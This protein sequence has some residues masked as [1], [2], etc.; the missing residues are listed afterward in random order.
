VAPYKRTD[1][2]FVNPYNFVSIDEPVRR[3]KV[4]YGGLTG[5]LNCTLETLTPLFVPNTTNNKTFS[6]GPSNSY[7]FYSYEDLSRS[8]ANN[9][10][11]FPRPIIPGSAIRGAIRAAYEAVTNSCLSTSDDENTLYRRTVVP[12]RECGIIVKENS[13]RVLYK[14]EK[15]NLPVALRGGH[16]MGAELRGGYY[17]R[18]EDFR[19]KKNDAIMI[20]KLDDRGERILTGK[21]YNESDDEWKRIYEVWRLYQ[22]KNSE[23][24]GV[25]QTSGH[26]AYKG[27]L[28]VKNMP[29]YYSV[30]DGVY[31]VSPACMTK[32]VFS[33]TVKSML[34]SQGGHQPCGDGKSLC[35]ACRLFGMVG[36]ENSRS[37]RLAFRDAKPV[38]DAEDYRDWYEQPRILPILSGPKISATEFYM[39][40]VAGAALFN[41]DYKTTYIY[42][43]RLQKKVPITEQ[44][45]NPKLRGRKFYWHSREVV[46]DMTMDF[47]RQRTEIRPVTRGKRFTFE[48]AFEQLSCGE[49]A[50]L[51]YTL[52]FGENAQTNAHKLGHGKPVG[53]GSVR[54]I[55]DD[56][57]FFEV[58]GGNFK[59]VEKT[60]N[61][62]DY[63]RT[64]PSKSVS[65]CEYLKLTAFE[66]APT[67][68][69]YPVAVKGRNGTPGTYAWF[70]INKEIVGG[71]QRPE[72]ND[73]LPLPLD[74]EVYVRGYEEGLGDKTGNRKSSSDGS[75]AAKA[76]T[77][78]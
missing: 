51:I 6:E 75:V 77:T 21:S 52:T 46:R 69:R 57:R 15:A 45:R 8:R 25:N 4:A 41:Y 16:K 67:P 61:L 36:D 64:P 7:D 68:V 70:G 17:L 73:V 11:R 9:G 43:R 20:F 27:W 78:P 22:Q 50:K 72:F 49:L 54:I 44:I 32:E 62:T 74:K 18:G 19:G 76:E 23:S 1:E 60:G 5:I 71:M 58:D 35:D 42:D 59:L 39:T 30:V 33:H 38:P 29:V 40:E 2:K 13:E 48:I 34:E 47:L 37:S 3:D 14:A 28:T 55:A 66:D 10:S 53:Y 56:I 65:V 24:K 12:K 63:R 26:S 31:Y